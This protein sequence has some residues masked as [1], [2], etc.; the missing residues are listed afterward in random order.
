M[1]LS[2]KKLTL[3]RASKRII[4][5]HQSQDGLSED[6]MAHDEKQ[7]EKLD[8]SAHKI[9][10]FLATHEKKTGSKGREVKS[11]ITDPDS[12]KMTTSKGTIQGYNVARTKCSH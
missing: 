1:S 7:K 9:T 11:N 10:A 12:A 6:V 5:R 4:A 2:V 3:E 8:T